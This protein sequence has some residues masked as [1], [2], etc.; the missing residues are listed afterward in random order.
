[1]GASVGSFMNVVIH[2]SPVML[3][4]A[5]LR[6]AGHEIPEYNL[7]FP[8]SACI[9]CSHQIT[10]YENI[11]IF[12]YLVLRG[13]CR[14]CKTRI[15]ARYLFVE[16]LFGIVFLAAWFACGSSILSMLI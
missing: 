5:R 3:R 14:C 8:R 15:S 12:S 9:K 11:P 4:N 6:R 1:M 13:Q 2:R 16:I 7:A 10:W